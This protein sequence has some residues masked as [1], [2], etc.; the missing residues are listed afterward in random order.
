MPPVLAC[1]KEMVLT[2]RGYSAV[3]RGV[4]GEAQADG[5]RERLLLLEQTADPHT[6]ACLEALGVE[7]GWRCL[8]VG[9]GAGSIA[10][11]LANRAG[12]SAVVATD[13]DVKFLSW[14]AREGVQVLPHDVN[15]DPRPGGDFSLI[16]A[17]HLLENM[18]ERDWILRRLVS[19]LA[20]GGSLAIGVAAVYPPLIRNE[21]VRALQAAA[22][23]LL[24]EQIGSAPSEWVTALPLLMEEAGLIDVEVDA[25]LRVAYRGTPQ[26]QL[27]QLTL[28][29][30]APPIVRAGLLTAAQAQ[31]AIA[32]LREPEYLGYGTVGFVVSGRLPKA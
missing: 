21:L 7:Q 18:P 29:E 30:A 28:P 31:A 6:I 25:R 16:H 5:E 3:R 15:I 27:D 20:P 9:A 4:W 12:P 13:I 14:L 11:W 32:E 22:Q 8:E 17:R 26:L 2:E 19:W 10:G 23:T 1:G 24:A